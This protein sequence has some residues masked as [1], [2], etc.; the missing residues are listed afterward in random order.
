VLT[1]FALVLV[2]GAALVVFVH[3]AAQQLRI[4][5]LIDLVGDELQAQLQGRYPGAGSGP[6]EGNVITAT[7][8]GNLIHVDH[9]GLVELARRADCALELVPMMGDFAMRETPLFRIHG[10]GSKLDAETIR[11][12]VTLDNER[13]HNDDPAYGFRKLVDV[14]QR[15]LGTSSNEATSAVQV[16]N[17]LHACLRQ[18]ADR[19]LPSGVHRDDA[20]VVRLTERTLGWDGYVRLAFDE[21]RLAGA[22]YPQV[23]RRICASIEDLKTLAPDD[24]QSP[25]DRQLRLLAAGVR[26][27]LDDEDDI[28]GALVPDAQGLGS[29]ADVA[30]A[31]LRVEAM[32][33][34]P[35]G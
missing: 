19:P 24:R 29:G 22:G 10:S 6:A 3:H 9:R 2:S 16:V 20:G 14:A 8:A 23:T 15:A 34:T 27:A 26:R 12:R 32:Q 31:R 18:I 28:R 1:A 25:L 35:I 33:V 11:P 17:R 5:G 21:I 4:G 7:S 13:T 30:D